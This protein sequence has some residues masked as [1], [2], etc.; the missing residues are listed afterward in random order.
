MNFEPVYSPS[1]K[2]STSVCIKT[3]FFRHTTVVP[4]N[5][6][7]SVQKQVDK[8]QLQKPMQDLKLEC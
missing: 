5:L 6:K 2:D 3:N 8:H 4:L 1:A 7:Q